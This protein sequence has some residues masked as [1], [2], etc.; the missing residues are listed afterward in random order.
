MKYQES[1]LGS[2]DESIR[3]LKEIFSKLVKDSL[4][5]EGECIK[6]PYDNDLEVKV[7]YEEDDYEGKLAIKI[8]WYYESDEED[9]DD[10][11]E[12]EI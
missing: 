1:Y 8:Q 7:K 4:E 10:E 3:N 2:R 5:I 12:V 9:I 6:L 11:L